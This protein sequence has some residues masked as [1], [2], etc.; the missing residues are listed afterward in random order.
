[1]NNL[2]R[3]HSL[4]FTAALLLSLSLVACSDDDDDDDSSYALTIADYVAGSYEA[5]ASASFVYISYDMVNTGDVVTITKSGDETVSITYTGET[6]GTGTFYDVSV[7]ASG[8]SYALSGSGTLTMAGHT[9]TSDYDATIEATIAS[10]SDFEIIISVPSVMGG[11]T[12]TLTPTVT[13]DYVVGDH[14]VYTEVMFTYISTPY[15][16]V[17]E[18]ISI[19]KA[20][21]ESVDVTYS[22]DTWGDWTVSGA[23]VT[24]TSSGYTIEGSGTAAVASH[25]GGT[26]EYDCTLTAT[27]DADGTITELVF[28]AAF[29]GTTT[30][31][32]Y[33]ADAP[34]AYVVAG[35]YTV[36]T[37]VVFAY[38]SYSYESETVT[39]EATSE[40]TVDVSYSNDTWGDFA[41]SDATV[42]ENEDGSYALSG[43][44][45]VSMDDHNGGTNDYEFTFE[46][47]ITDSSDFT[48]SFS[49][50]IMGGTTITM[51]PAAA[52]E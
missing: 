23:T 41:V 8:S 25:S 33:E 3:Y 19:T 26:S 43:T 10:S 35:D 37:E 31:T 32:C 34:A 29:M 15:T 20:G 7:T 45:T 6:W 36:D 42:T 24:A 40:T 17:D 38:G 46:G 13:A 39:I 47:T 1:M 11:T 12:I 27:L 52:E 50:E 21:D 22:N 18:T 28:T 30:I 44:G 9:S 5:T 49:L 51:T 14:T 16:F 48:L 2:K 4:L